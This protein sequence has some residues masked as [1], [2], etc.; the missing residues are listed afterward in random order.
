MI[1]DIWNQKIEWQLK[2]CLQAVSD[3]DE[4]D[5]AY[6]TSMIGENVVNILRLAEDNRQESNFFLIVQAMKK[7]V[8]LGI[9]SK[10]YNSILTEC[11]NYYR[12]DTYV[13]IS[14]I[15]FTYDE[16]KLIYDEIM[17]LV[18][19]VKEYLIQEGKM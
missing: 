13:N 2:K 4:R 3:R 10:D 19:E 7:Y 14:S 15:P 11:Y 5:L 12:L 18:N 6:R 1:K 8:A 17:N 9:L 16:I